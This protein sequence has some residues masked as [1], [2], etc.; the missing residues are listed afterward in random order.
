MVCIGIMGVAQQASAVPPGGPG[1]GG[2]G[3]YACVHCNY[4]SFSRTYDCASGGGASS[5]DVFLKSA[6]PAVFGC[7][8]YL[9]PCSPAVG[10]F[11]P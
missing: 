8:E 5:C 7:V 6:V 11:A 9:G 2:A 10:G 4:H 3:G 1:G